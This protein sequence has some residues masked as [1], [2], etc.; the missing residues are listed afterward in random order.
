MHS[1]LFGVSRTLL[2][3]RSDWLT[4]NNQSENPSYESREE[5]NITKSIFHIL[6]DIIRCDR[7]KVIFIN[8]NLVT[9]ISMRSKV[10]IREIENFDM[11]YSIKKILTCYNRIRNLLSSEHILVL[12]F[13]GFLSCSV[14]NL[15]RWCYYD[16]HILWLNRSRQIYTCNSFRSKSPVEKNEFRSEKGCE[17]RSAFSCIR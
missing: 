2:F 7:F 4:E 15:K 1:R 11:K 3:K 12:P 14:Y 6:F 13:E 9:R 16:M 5:L 8:R 10:I 17:C